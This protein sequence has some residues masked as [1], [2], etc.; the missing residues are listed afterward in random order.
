MKHHPLL[1]IEEPNV[2]FIP[3]DVPAIGPTRELAMFK[4]RNFINKHSIFHCLSSYLPAF[5][6]YIPS[7]VTIHDLKYMLFPEFFSNRFKTLYYNWIIRRGIRNASY[8]IAVSEATRR[9]VENL[10]VRSGKMC[11]IHEAPTVLRENTE[12]L[13]DILRN[14]EYFLFVGEQRPHK[15]TRRIINAYKIIRQKLGNACPS[16]V[17]AGS[18]FRPLEEFSNDDI[19]A[20]GPVDEQSLATLY[21]KALALVYPSL[22][23]GFGL[24]I[25]EAMSLGT[26]VITSNCSSMHEVAGGA[27]LLVNPHST[28]QLAAAMMKLVQRKELGSML[29]SLG[30]RRIKAFSWE[31]A[32]LEMCNVYQQLL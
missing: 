29:T 21:K 9:D 2:T 16:L 20:L 12:N 18:K 25:V 1:Q 32:A 10:G 14:K 19:I 4:L 24:P 17:F 22:Y 26:P 3:V 13:P 8:L 11:V 23:E 28:A 15:N 31:I 6:V 5:G 30:Y 27:A 7:I